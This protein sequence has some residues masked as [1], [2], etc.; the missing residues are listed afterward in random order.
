MIN[1]RRSLSNVV[2]ACLLLVGVVALPSHGANAQGA[3]RTFPETGQTVKGRFLEYWNANGGLPQQGYPISAE[4]QEKSD[5][6]G[7]TYTVQYFER[8]VFESHPEN[9][10]PFDVLLSLLG[11]FYYAQKHQGGAPGQ[12]PNTSTG[13]RLF[14]ETGKRLGG[15]FLE[16][17]RANGG[18]T[19][20]GLP[21]SDEFQERNA[22]DG[23]TY[24]VQ[25]FERAVFESHTENQPPFDVLLSQLGT[26]RHRAKYSAGGAPPSTPVP[27]QVAA[28]TGWTRLAATGEGPKARADHSAIY[29]PV[30]NRLVVFGGRGPGGALGDTWILDLGTNAWRE[31]KGDGPPARF[32]HGAV[33]DPASRRLIVIMGQGT[34]FYNDVWGF[35]LDK[36]VWNAVK[37]NRNMADAPRTRYGQSAALD[38]KGRV[39]VSHGFSDQG[40]FDDTWAFDLATATWA[41]ITPTSGQKPLK[42]C[43]HELVYSAASDTLYLFGGCS[44][45]FGPCPQGD[46]WALDLKTNTW[47]ELGQ[48]TNKPS[49]RSNPTLSIDS[50]GKRLLLFGGK[51]TAASAETWSYDLTGAAWTRV[52]ATG[53]VARSSQATA[54]DP[55]SNR[56]FIVGGQT[57]D[58]ATN[59]VWELK[60]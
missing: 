2:L 54:H 6:D 22:L 21:I 27:T 19:Q 39:I 10:P 42:R 20:Q 38:G 23:K 1:R 9:S 36:E 13:S 49:P 30:K 28:G 50:A 43:L 60:Y 31:V 41:D 5:T 32:G 24:T 17:W 14:T 26:F 15:R 16:Y 34:I 58:G 33:Y 25:Y 37:G 11:N 35:D 53:P 55:K 47:R 45:G 8:A 56:L 12:K 51:T 40:R 7:K 18:L 29:D 48:G 4:I 57:S 46:L 3:S 59:D 44:S 52:D